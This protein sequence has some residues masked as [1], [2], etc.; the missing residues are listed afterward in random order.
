[1][2]P[3]S[4]GD[5]IDVSGLADDEPIGHL[6]NDFPSKWTAGQERRWRELCEEV[7]T[8]QWVAGQTVSRST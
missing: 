8:E 3:T 5:R 7:D 1:M 4:H 6:S 2:T